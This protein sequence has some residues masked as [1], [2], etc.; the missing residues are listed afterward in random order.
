MACG[1]PVVATDRCIAAKELI[2]NDENGYVVPA[3]NPQALRD[4]LQKV[5]SDEGLRERM[6]VNNLKK[7]N[8]CTIDAI[9][10][11]HIEVIDTL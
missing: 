11:K 4:A 2:Q 1:L 10:K 9:V 8:G 6:S 3:E 5:L 7:I